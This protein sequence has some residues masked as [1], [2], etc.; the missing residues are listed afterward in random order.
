MCGYAGMGDE[1]GG[2]DLRMGAMRR[3]V[4]V[5]YAGQLNDGDG[6]RSRVLDMGGYVGANG[7]VKCAMGGVADGWVICG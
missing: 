2:C 4:G 1:L 5:S 6:A 7:W 3:W